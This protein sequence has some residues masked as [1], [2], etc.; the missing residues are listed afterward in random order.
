MI[1][2]EYVP[3][4]RSKWEEHIGRWQAEIDARGN[5][6][7]GV[8][9]GN[10]AGDTLSVAIF[11]F[12]MDGNVAG[13]RQRIGAATELRIGLLQRYHDG[14]PLRERGP[15]RPDEPPPDRAILKSEVSNEQFDWM[16]YA[17]AGARLDLAVQMAS[18]FGT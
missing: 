2:K 16:F 1:K 15:R 3:K 11:A 9:T 4:L 7:Y 6:D 8:L 10:I 14:L 17:M 13:F 18:L 5:D 12:A